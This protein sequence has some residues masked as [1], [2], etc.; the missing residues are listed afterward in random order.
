VSSTTSKLQSRHQSPANG[1]TSRGEH[2]SNAVEETALP[3][4]PTS[5]GLTISPTMGAVHGQKVNG[6]NN[7]RMEGYI[8]YIQNYQSYFKH[9]K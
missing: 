3:C 4:H 9:K 7:L 2:P 5:P 6:N 8:T 1:G